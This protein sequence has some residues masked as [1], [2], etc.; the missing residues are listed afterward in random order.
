MSL[1]ITIFAVVPRLLVLQIKIPTYESSPEYLTCTTDVA[2]IPPIVAVNAEFAI[3]P[4]QRMVYRFDA[5]APK[6]TPENV[7]ALLP[8][9]FE[10]VVVT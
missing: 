8:L 4:M 10:P 2:D 1:S 3:D 9:S 5:V 6:L 7:N